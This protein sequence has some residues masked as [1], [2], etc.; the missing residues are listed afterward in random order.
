MVSYATLFDAGPSVISDRGAQEMTPTASIRD[1]L[2]A[3]VTVRHDL[4]TGDISRLIALHAILHAEVRGWD[5]TFEAYVAGP[6]AEFALSHSER[7]RIWIVDEGGKLTGSVA[8]V[9]ASEEEAQLRWLLLVPHLRGHGLG[10]MLVE[11]AVDFCRE[12]GYGSVFLW[13]VEGLDA[14][15][16]LYE[17]L[18]FELTEEETHPIWGAVVTEQRYELAL[19]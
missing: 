8:I 1:N 12:A 10:R 2:P 16:H 14:A 15:L 5:A 3:N 7:E 17:S 18:G 13:T 6:L 9:E 19:R 11:E 4:R